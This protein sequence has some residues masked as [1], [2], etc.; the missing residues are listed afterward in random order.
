MNWWIIVP[1]RTLQFKI[2]LSTDFN[3]SDILSE[4][5]FWQSCL[6]GVMKL[7][8]KVCFEVMAYVSVCVCLCS[9]HFWGHLLTYRGPNIQRQSTHPQKCSSYLCSKS[10]YPYNY[11]VLGNVLRWIMKRVHQCSVLAYVVLVQWTL[12][13]TNSLGSVKLLCSIEILLYPG[14]KNNNIQRNFE[15]C[16]QENDFVISGFCYISVLYNECPL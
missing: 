14:C 1:R 2:A 6:S 3:V 15:L 4:A 7:D 10:L 11:M 8:K 16:Y 12:A 5:Y 13:L 9:I